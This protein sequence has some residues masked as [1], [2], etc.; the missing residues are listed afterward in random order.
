MMAAAGE[1]SSVQ[2]SSVEAPVEQEGEKKEVV[3]GDDA[4]FKKPL[5]PARK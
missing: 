4:A 5:P 2:A 1:E 3:G